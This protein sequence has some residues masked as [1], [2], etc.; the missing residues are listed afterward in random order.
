MQTRGGVIAAAIAVVALALLLRAGAAVRAESL[1][2]DEANDV[3]LC[4]NAHGVGEMLRMLRAEG[5]PPLR[6]SRFTLRPL[7]RSMAP[8]S[9]RR[10]FSHNPASPECSLMMLPL[11]NA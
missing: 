3:F 11:A 1:W 9:S 6:L 10:M 2:R 8:I 5:S 7:I 4:R